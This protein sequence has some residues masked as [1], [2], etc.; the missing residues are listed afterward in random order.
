MSGHSQIWPIK[1]F[2]LLSFSQSNQCS[3]LGQWKLFLT[4][5]GSHE[6]GE[7]LKRPPRLSVIFSSPQHLAEV[8]YICALTTKIDCTSNLTIPGH[9]CALSSPGMASAKIVTRHCLPK[10]NMTSVFNCYMTFS[11]PFKPVFVVWT[12]L[13]CMAAKENT[14]FQAS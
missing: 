14:R 8:L 10:S 9:S 3:G 2:L 5:P 1:Q 12:A 6:G 13:L 11:R 4:S 7:A